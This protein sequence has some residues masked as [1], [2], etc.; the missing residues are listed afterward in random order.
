MGE[1]H[2][3]LKP[4]KRYSVAMHAANLGDVSALAVLVKRIVDESGDSAGFD[5]MAWV[6]RWVQ[7]PSPALGGKCP[8]AFMATPDGRAQVE[9]LIMRMQS[10]AYS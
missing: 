7:H 6:S 8:A 1:R 2:G 10:G 4:K 9:A 3:T 5:P